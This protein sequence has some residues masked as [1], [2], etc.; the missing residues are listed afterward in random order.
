MKCGKIKKYLTTLGK[1]F[2]NGNMYISVVEVDFTNFFIFTVSK[3]FRE[4]ILPI[5]TKS[6]FHGIFVQKE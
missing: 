4:I 1:Y 3:I 5:I 2:A 6:W